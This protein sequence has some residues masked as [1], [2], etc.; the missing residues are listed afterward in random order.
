MLSAKTSGAEPK[1]KGLETYDLSVRSVDLTELALRQ[2]QAQQQLQDLPWHFSFTSRAAPVSYELANSTVAK[3]TLSRMQMLMGGGVG[4]TKG[5]F[6]FTLQ[7][8]VVSTGM[9]GGKGQGQVLGSLGLA[10]AE[11]QA[12]AGI[13]LNEHDGEGFGLD[14]NGNFNASETRVRPG[15]PGSVQQPWFI[16]KA[17]NSLLLGGYD[18]NSGASIQA[19]LGDRYKLNVTELPDGSRYYRQE[20]ASWGVQTIRLNFQPLT[21]YL[22]KDI[23]LPFIGIA[24]YRKSLGDV[25]RSSSQSSRSTDFS[26]GADDVLQ[27]GLRWRAVLSC[28]CRTPAIRKG[29]L[30]SDHLIPVILI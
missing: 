14:A 27:G 5:G 22:P 30:I 21:Y 3:G 7:G 13:L 16:Q 2:A 18:G 28:S 19:Q 4:D 1:L 23:G 10:F 8:D 15:A 29:R 24:N 6:F 17:P 12:F 20:L 11:V 25:S 26:L 9:P